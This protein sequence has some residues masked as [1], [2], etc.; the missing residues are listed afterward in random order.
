MLGDG[1]KGLPGREG[2][3][4]EEANGVVG[5]E[6]PQLG[7]E[8][9]QVVVMY[10][11]EIVGAQQRLQLLRQ[12]PV[13]ADIALKKSRLELSEVETVVKDRPQHRVAVAQVIGL[14]VGLG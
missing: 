4:Q 14:I 2:N 6:P 8:R 3:M 13:D 12:A 5:A 10:P 7:G 9:Q 11:N 1:H